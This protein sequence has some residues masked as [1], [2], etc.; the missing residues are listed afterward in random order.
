MSDVFE[1]QW[2]TALKKTQ[3]KTKIPVST[4]KQI[5]LE[6]IS[7]LKDK[8]KTE[9][10]TPT[11]NLKII[12]EKM[13]AQRTKLCA[14]QIAENNTNEKSFLKSWAKDCIFLNTLTENNVS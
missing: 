4:R 14:L 2:A 3:Q 5:V 11:G 10:D 12:C 7:A 13:I 1:Q 8:L 6:K 9:L